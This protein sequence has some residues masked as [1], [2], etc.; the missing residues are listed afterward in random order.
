[1]SP[2]S[3]RRLHQGWQDREREI[4]TKRHK[5]RQAHEER[6]KEE[7]GEGETERQRLTCLG[8]N[9]HGLFHRYMHAGD[10]KMGDH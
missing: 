2:D 6:H 8:Q 10:F 9:F 3:N 7:D 4:H 5:V 1:M